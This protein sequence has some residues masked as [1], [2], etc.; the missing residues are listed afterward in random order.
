MLVERTQKVHKS[1]AKGWWFT[2][3]SLVLS[4]LNW[5]SC[6]TEKWGKNKK[7]C[8]HWDLVTVVF[9]SRRDT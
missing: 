6:Y 5:L 7:S 4:T 2:N 3:Y 8:K 1:Q 9:G